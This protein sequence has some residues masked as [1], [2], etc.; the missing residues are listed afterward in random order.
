MSFFNEVYIGYYEVVKRCGIFVII[1][2]VEVK[3]VGKRSRVCFW[4]IN[5]KKKRLLEYNWI[6]R[7]RCINLFVKFY[8]FW[9]VCLVIWML[10]IYLCLKN[11]DGYFCKWWFV[12]FVL[13]IWRKELKVRKR[14]RILYWMWWWIFVW[15]FIWYL[16]LLGIWFFLLNE[17]KCCCLF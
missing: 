2:K 7:W 17:L 10:N 1:F 3:E 11:R 5:F 13:I 6:C 14:I 9:W 16:G 15:I 12:W 8:V 4:G